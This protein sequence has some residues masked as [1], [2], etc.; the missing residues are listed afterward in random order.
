MTTGIIFVLEVR[1]TG[2][3][4]RFSGEQIENIQGILNTCYSKVQDI[5]D[6]YVSL[7][8]TEVSL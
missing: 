6:T 2:P 7:E 5:K 4:D 8:V 1:Y 3:N